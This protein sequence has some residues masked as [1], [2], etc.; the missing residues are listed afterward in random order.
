MELF[1]VQPMHT[2]DGLLKYMN[3]GIGCARPEDL[4]CPILGREA[5]DLVIPVNSPL[6][7]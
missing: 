7:R 3:R 4:L 5:R 1:P 6:F 2:P